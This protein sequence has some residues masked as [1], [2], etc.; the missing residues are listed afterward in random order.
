MSILLHIIGIC[1]YVG[2]FLILYRQMQHVRQSIRHALK[3]EADKIHARII[4]SANYIKPK[5]KTEIER[6]DAA[7]ERARG[8]MYY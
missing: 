4:E 7:T 3:A 6:R 5:Q 1:I 2:G 8:E